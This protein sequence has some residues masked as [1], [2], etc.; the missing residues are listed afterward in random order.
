MIGGG[1]V[2]YRL[3]DLA[4]L[5][6]M[7]LPRG[8]NQYFMTAWEYEHGVF[9]GVYITFVYVDDLGNMCY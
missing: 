6:T 8:I 7:G 9:D 5:I 3:P 2:F 4:A 1:S